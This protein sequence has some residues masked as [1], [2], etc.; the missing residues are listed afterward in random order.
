MCY[1]TYPENDG[2]LKLVLDCYKLQE[3]CYKAVDN[4]PHTSEFFPESYKT[5]KM[6][7]ILSFYNKTCF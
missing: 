3:M 7:L 1:K 6:L 5:Q 2:T 4:Y